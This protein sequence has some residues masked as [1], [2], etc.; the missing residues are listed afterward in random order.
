MIY[1][2]TGPRTALCQCVGKKLLALADVFPD[3]FLFPLCQVRIRVYDGVKRFRPYEK[4]WGKKMRI[5]ALDTRG[6]VRK[7]PGAGFPAG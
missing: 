4:I 7:N 6:L 3:L 1:I 2:L 5:F